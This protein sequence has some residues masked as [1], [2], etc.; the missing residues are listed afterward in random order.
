MTTIKPNWLATVLACAG[1]LLSATH[2]Q[3]LDLKDCPA[4][5]VKTVNDNLDDGEKVTSIKSVT[6]GDW[7]YFEVETNKEGYMT[8]DPDGTLESIDLGTD[9]SDVPPLAKKAIKNLPGKLQDVYMELND[10][11]VAE[12][13]VEKLVKRS[14]VITKISADGSVLK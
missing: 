3:A 6:E 2:S 1:I 4:A 14:V 9:L 7:T 12:Y 13:T 8:V 10:N 5:V 11:M